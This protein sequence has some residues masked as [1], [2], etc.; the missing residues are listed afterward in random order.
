MVKVLEK[1]EHDR[2]T[3]LECS[4]V[5]QSYCLD[6]VYKVPRVKTQPLSEAFSRVMLLYRKPFL[7]L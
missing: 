1:R 4:V 6:L 2:M 7:S 3:E 5:R